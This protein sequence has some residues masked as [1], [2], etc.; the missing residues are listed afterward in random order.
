MNGMQLRWVVTNYQRPKLQYR[1]KMDT[2]IRAGMWSNED[3]LK[4]ANFEWT[5]WLDV[6]SVNAEDL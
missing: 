5:D 2:T 6:P 3:M 1:Y 4:T